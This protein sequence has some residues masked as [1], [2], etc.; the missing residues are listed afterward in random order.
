MSFWHKKN[1]FM[2]L[3][4][5]KKYYK[6]EYWPFYILYLPFTPLYLYFSL[7]NRSLLYFT[8]ANPGIHYGGLF[9]YS[10]SAINQK[11]PFPFQLKEIQSLAT[12]EFPIIA[13]PDQGERGKNVHVVQKKEDLDKIQFQ[14]EIFYQEYD[15][16]PLEFGVFYSKIPKKRGE[17]ISIT[18]KR[19]LT[20]YGDGRTS[21]E[22]FI[23][24]DEKAFLARHRLLQKY[25]NQLNLILQP[26]EKLV[27][28]EV[29]NHN[30]GTT[31]LDGNNY[32]SKALEKNID[33]VAQQI[34]GFYYG[35]FD[36]KTSSVKAF[37]KGVFKVIEINGVNSEPTHIYDPSYSISQ[38]FREIYKHLKLQ[39]K[40]AHSHLKDGFKTPNFWTF[41]RDLYFH[42]LRKQ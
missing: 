39:E 32:F 19:F 3:Y 14:G 15:N 40:I 34:P 29:G 8:A 31:F 13:K 35:R 7:K 20:F 16:S 12:A 10:K 9:N 26:D 37:K 23:Y 28:E 38:A 25:K 24:K 42:L 1:K 41:V 2:F 33:F 11:V 5:L 22:Q 18:A 6:F 36:V 17:I 27:I 30:R 4:R 21:L